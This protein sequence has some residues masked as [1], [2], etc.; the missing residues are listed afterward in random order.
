MALDLMWVAIVVHVAVPAGLA[1]L[2]VLL[3]RNKLA[4][5]WGRLSFTVPAAMVLVAVLALVTMR[6]WSIFPQ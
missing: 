3:F 4:E 5:P 6:H 1:V 2:V